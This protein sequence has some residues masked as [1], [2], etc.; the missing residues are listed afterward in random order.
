MKKL[1]ITLILLVFVAQIACA[2]NKNEPSVNNKVYLNL[3]WWDRYNDPL[4][5]EYLR[6][7]YEKNHDL[8][9][10]TLKVKEGERLV[11]LS[12]ANELPH[13][14]FDGYLNR[15]FK[16]SDLYFGNLQIKDF[17]QSELQ[18]PLTMSY[19]IDIWGVNRFR[20]KSIEKQLDMVKQD[21]RASYIALTSSFAADYFNFIRL[22]KLIDIQTQ[23]LD[24]QK[25]IV[26]KTQI[27]FDNGLCSKN[28]VLNEQKA[29]TY[30]QE[31]LNNL[32]DKRDVVENQLRV[33]LS[34]EPAAEIRHAEYD[35]LQLLDNLP[36]HFDSDVITQRPDFLSAE[37]NIKRVGYNVKAAKRD[38][39]PK[40]VLWGQ[41]GFNAYQFNKLFSSPAQ[42]A[43]AGILPQLDIFDGARKWNVMKLRKLEYDEA[44]QVY[45]KTILTSFQELNDALSASN[46]AQ[47]NYKDC[48]ERLRYENQVY[49]L[50]DKK[51]KIG[52]ASDLELLYAKQRQLLTQ[53]DEVVSKINCLISSIGLYK[54]VG[55]QDL[56]KIVEHI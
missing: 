37:S 29:L 46:N 38:F 30:F 47:K 14:S 28:E 25:T 23:V 12:F 44:F 31:E 48:D 19:E 21:E 50:V 22:D 11:K 41:L 53:K 7:V 45:E 34:N 49:E 18:L 9:I 52:A 1:L 24:L 36:N 35:D 55:G 40:F 2:A 20:T 26:K 54:A 3:E 33:Y 5:S 27:K 39:L 10:A 4:L 15:N 6:T 17:K 16:S 56:Y 51:Q 42:M 32:I 13:L 43:A 8:K